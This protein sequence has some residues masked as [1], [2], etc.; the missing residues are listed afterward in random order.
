[1]TTPDYA[2]LRVRPAV[3]EDARRLVRQIAAIADR[4]VTQ[5]EAIGAAL[6]YALHNA[7]AVAE[8]LA[9]AADSG[10]DP[11]L[12]NRRRLAHAGN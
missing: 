3:A 5:T 11:A 6:T 7:A 4:D 1:M 12:S 8:L 2:S 10:G 9:D